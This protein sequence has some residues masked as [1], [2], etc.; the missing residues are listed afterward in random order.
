MSRVAVACSGDP[1]VPGRFSGIP[2][3]LLSALEELGVRGVPI[4][5]EP[6]VRVHRAV[7][8]AMQLTR[9]RPRDLLDLRGSLATSHWAVT[10]TR[11]LASARSE[12]A[13]RALRRAGPL[14]GVIQYGTDFRL[15]PGTPY[16]TYEDSTVRSAASAYDWPWL[17][18]ATPR[19]LDR[20]ADYASARYAGAVRCCFTSHWAA[21]SAIADHGVPPEKVRVV[22]IGN[23]HVPPSPERDW[24]VPR[25]LFVG[26]DWRR[27]NGDGLL[28]AFARL[29]EELPEATLDLVGGHPEVDQPGVR[30]HGPLPIDSPEGRRRVEELY[31]Q[32]TCFVL[33]SLHEPSAISHVEA[34]AAGLPSIGSTVGGVATVIGDG[35]IL[36]DPDDDAIL[37][38]LRRLADPATAAALGAR[39]K[40]HAERLTWHAVADRLLDALEVRPGSVADL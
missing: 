33:P 24:R 4:A 30:A 7:I 22:G 23:N 39:A 16:V 18:G 12:A 37:A 1:L 21:A 29:H 17:A 10:S 35:G 38:G 34:S 6:S 40:V 11:V 36:V 5:A 27:K 8:G 19:R 13:A 20:W 25:F 3:S 9:L 31:A 14:D 2:I 26:L 28:R 32:A 15:P